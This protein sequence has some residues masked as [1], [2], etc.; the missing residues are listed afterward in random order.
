MTGPALC[1]DNVVWSDWGRFTVAELV[2]RGRTALQAAPDTSP[3]VLVATNPLDLLA[4]ACALAALRRD[5]M[6]LP[7]ERLTPS[8]RERLELEGFAELDLATSTLERAGAARA[9]PGHVRLLTSGSTGEPKLI[10]HTWESL[11]TMARVRH[12]RPA[13]WLLTYQAGTYAW[14]QLATALMFIPHQGLVLAGG[15]SPSDLIAAASTSQVTAISSTPTFWRLALLQADPAMLGRLQST[16]ESLTLGGE[17]VDQPIL[18]RLSGLFP[19]ARLVH[20]YASSEVGASIIVADGRAGFP[21]EWLGDERR[22]PQI[23][24]EDGTLRLRSPHAAIGLEGWYDTGDIAEIRSGRVHL[25]GRLGRAVINVGGAKAFA[26]DIERVI[27]EHPFVLWCRVR[28]VR[29]PLV[30][31]LVAAEIVPQPAGIGR[32]LPEAE[33]TSFCAER[34]PTHMVPRIWERLERI[35]ATEN[36][37]TEV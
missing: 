1:P 25:L 30:G 29:A 20:I 14:F 24:V 2:E 16:L 8:V 32:P 33:L 10:H 31:Q 11:F 28:G 35:P 12:P 26:A 22:S 7:R 4:G 15:P 27:L 3:V 19:A 17:P 13:R 5:G 36:W 34:L 21:V 37:K 18:D 6:V 23:R 9:V